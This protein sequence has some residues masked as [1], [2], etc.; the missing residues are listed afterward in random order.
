MGGPQPDLPIALTMGEPS[1]IGLDVTI[2]AWRRRGAEAVP[3][4]YCLADPDALRRR[5]QILGSP[6]PIEETTTAAAISGFDSFLP[7]VPLSGAVA[8]E[9][10]KPDGDAARFVEEAITRAVEDVRNGHAASVVTNPI[11]KAVM[12]AAGFAHPGHTDFLGELAAEW[13]GE[14]VKPV[15]MLA[16]PELRTV[17][18]TVHIA[19]SEVPRRLTEELIVETGKI[20]NADL[21]R[22]FGIRRPR[23]AVTGLNPHAGEEGRLGRED[24]AVVRPAIDTLRGRDID[25]SGPHPADTLFHATAR[26]GYDAALCMYH[27]QALIP[28]KTLAFD[29]AVNVT[30]GLPFIRT[31]PDHGTAFARAG[32]GTANPGSLIAA[33]KLAAQMATIEA[34]QR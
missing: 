17:P 23:I 15:M 26:K 1:G 4:F 16:G 2:A 33:L 34:S 10:G 30:L 27:D 7:V 20:L 6:I 19:L 14:T 11:N 13:T 21:K 28:A 5:A 31:S 3:P 18:V 22:R 24:D 9:P 12:L 25:A 32:T 29:E 8:G